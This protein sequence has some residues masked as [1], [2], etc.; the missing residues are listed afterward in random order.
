MAAYQSIG[1]DEEST[2]LPRGSKRRYSHFIVASITLVL[3][4]TLLVFSH[5]NDSK[6]NAAEEKHSVVGHHISVPLPTG[7]NLGSWVRECFHLLLL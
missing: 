6:K 2:E 7:V 5:H 3:I 1:V 4:A